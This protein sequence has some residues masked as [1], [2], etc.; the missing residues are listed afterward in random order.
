MNI[1]D[2]FR[3]QAFIDEIETLYGKTGR[4]LPQ[5]LFLH[6][7][8]DHMA[9]PRPADGYPFSA[10]YVV[11]NDY[12]LGR[13]LDFL[14]HKPWWKNMAVFITEDDAQ[15]GVDHIDSHRTVFLLASPYAKKNHSAK[16]NASFPALLKTVFRL[17]NLPPLN[18]FD[19]TAADLSECFTA[20]PDFAPYEVVPVDPEVFVP[21]E[22]RDPLD[23]KPS[24]RMDD[25]SVLREQ[26]RERG[27]NGQ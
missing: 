24:P 25:P 9:K 12:A 26:H 19:A 2:Q 7:P 4:P 21:S 6:L 5:L 16:V 22:A 17:L 13:I 23:P 15:G 10:S 14:S 11:D 3:A 8:N 27:R 18:L 20:Q 1:P